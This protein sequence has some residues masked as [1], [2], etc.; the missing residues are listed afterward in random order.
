MACI[1]FGTS[2]VNDDAA[3]KGAKF[4]ANPRDQNPFVSFPRIGGW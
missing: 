1:G 2:P 3:I 4:L